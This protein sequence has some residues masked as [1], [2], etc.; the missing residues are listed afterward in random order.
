ML[1]QISSMNGGIYKTTEYGTCRMPTKPRD[2]SAHAKFSAINKNTA[3]S[4]Q[5]VNVKVT[6]NLT[7][8]SQKEIQSWHLSTYTSSEQLAKL[9]KERDHELVL[10][11]ELSC[12]RAEVES[13]FSLSNVNKTYIFTKIAFDLEKTN[14]I[15]IAEINEKPNCK[16]YI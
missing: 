13:K 3:H 15:D 2:D 4:K 7:N 9:Q 1:E 5:K 12:F 10:K 6:Q 11:K 14:S 16:I 8:K